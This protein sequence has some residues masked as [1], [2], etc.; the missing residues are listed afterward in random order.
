MRLEDMKKDF[1]ETENCMRINNVATG[2]TI[3]KGPAVFS[4]ALYAES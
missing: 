3:V 2:G 4:R 1:P